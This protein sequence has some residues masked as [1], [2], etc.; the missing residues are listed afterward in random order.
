MQIA[1]AGP[2]TATGVYVT[3]TFQ[4]G[5][6]YIS[7]VPSFGTIIKTNNQVIWNLNLMNS[8]VTQTLTVTIRPNVAGW[9][10]NL[11]I[12]RA[13]SNDADPSD[14]SVQTLV[15]AN[16]PPGIQ[17]LAN[18][19]INEDGAVNDLAFTIGDR[20]TPV[21]NLVLSADS[22]DE[23]VVPTSNI[24]FGGSGS[25]RTV[26]IMPLPD[27]WGPVTVS[28]TVTDNDGASSTRS[29]VLTV[30][31][32]NDPPTLD[33]IGDRTVD[34]DAGPQ[35]VTLTGITGGPANEPQGAISITAT[36]SDPTIVPH[37]AI[38]YV[39]GSPTG[40]LTFA[41][42]T[43][44][45]GTAVIT[46]RVN[47][48]GTS[49]NIVLQS[50]A[51]TINPVND[52][53]TLNPIS[54]LSINEDAGL[55][56]ITLTGISG[57]PANE[58]QTPSVTASNSNPALLRDLAVNYTSGS[59]GT[60]TFGTVTNAYGSALVT[61]TL[62]DG[63]NS[64]NVVARTFE[65][66]VNPVNDRPALDAIAN[67]TVGENAGRQTVTLSG[68]T[69]GAENEE[70]IVLVTASNSAS[71]L[72]ANL[73]VDY[74]SPNPTGT[75]TF[76]VVPS[77]F[78]TNTITVTVR[79]DGTSNNV[80]T[81]TFTVAVLP[82]NDPPTMDL[83][84]DMI[85]P[86]DAGLQTIV[87]TGISEGAANETAQSM[88]ITAVSSDPLVVPN[89]TIGYTNNQQT[90]WL[91]FTPAANASGTAII[92]V[93][94]R[95]N[96]G[97]AVGGVDTTVRTFQ[98]TIM[99]VNDPPTLGTINNITV[100]E[101]SGM[102]TVNLTGIA[103]GANESE[104]LAVNASTTATDLIRNLQVAYTSPENT[105]VLTFGTVSNA[106]G[107]ATIQVD[108]VD[109][110]NTFTRNFNV[111]ITPINDAPTLDQPADLALEED[112]ASYTVNL[113]G[114]TGGAANEPQN[115]ITITAT[116][117]SPAVVSA[118]VVSY[119]RP[120]TT[121]SLV[122]NPV[123]NASGTA[124]I[125]VRVTDGATSNN[126]TVRTFT[127]TVTAANDLP[128]IGDVPAQMTL[129]DVPVTVAFTVSDVETAA[130]SLTLNAMSFNEEVVGNSGFT[131]GGTGNNRTLTIR[132][133]P[134][135]SGSATIMITAED[136]NGG[137]NSI[138]FEL[139]VNPVNDAPRISAVG[140]QT[141]EQDSTMTL[142]FTVADLECSASGVTVAVSSGNQTLVPAGG[143]AL[144]RNGGECTLRITPAAGRYGNANLT[145]TANDNAGSNNIATLV[146]SLHVNGLPSIAPI[147]DQTTPEDV[148]LTIPLTVSDPETP[149]TNMIVTI[150]S[151]NPA[152][153]PTNSIVVS[154]TGSARTVTITPT[155]ND[156]GTASIT[157]TIRDADGSSAST[158]F[159]MT[160]R[161]VN[162][163]PTISSIAPQATQANTPIQVGFTVG[164][165]ET[166]ATALVVA[167]QSS[168]QG[169]VPSGNLVCSGSGASRQVNIT[170]SADQTGTTQ[171]TVTAVDTNGASTVTSFVLTV[172]GLN[173][174]P[175]IST[176]PNLAINEDTWRDRCH[177]R[178]APRG[179][180][181]RT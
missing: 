91:R 88:T 160:V 19:T 11:A 130:N 23:A 129:E 25:N 93:T 51:V 69:S 105:A 27:V 60:L 179:R 133:L 56:T 138:F 62:S 79:D 40:T 126:V 168:N 64:N 167:A 145:I 55:Q 100:L 164:D 1:N 180:L 142:G 157:L 83:I 173:Q 103:A 152:L 153:I 22:S 54:D 94:A 53:P 28:R 17:S 122:L 59:S 42:A 7:A 47:D 162:D 85:L 32:V 178:S 24:I 45:V 71:G 49:N 116:S 165:V 177:S 75:L 136:A 50:F 68:I 63:A 156:S 98:V 101:D 166:P 115:T 20:E 46:V 158:T 33:P 171:I 172:N 70:Q 81:R 119:T 86:E 96:G 30:A 80:A 121:G 26:T 102:A 43:N 117:S 77:A 154:G 58:G 44:A 124:T 128:S 78:G 131:F 4:W 118:P 41:P 35:L 8:N 9:V 97:T 159:L 73:A 66:T 13:T 67:V 181:P 139:Y 34:E 5:S 151:S 112:F 106:F 176:L 114:I 65:V 140:P 107:T 18:R 134:D 48:G 163:A 29:F 16:A 39:V 149:V 2:S 31:A 161:A 146:F 148:P 135:Q 92:T 74:Q 147:A 111:T 87:L 6:T 123:A 95:D 76:D 132:P 120:A 36:S 52:L 127:V 38:S 170:P 15:R 141:C 99:P 155:L 110:E 61:V 21:A 113:T 125:T 57:G 10:T 144:T 175:T 3:N 12:I 89:P 90:A 84:G 109:A 150:T 143:L 72:L 169:L 82:V 174:L 14:N 108:V 104:P 137:A 37:P